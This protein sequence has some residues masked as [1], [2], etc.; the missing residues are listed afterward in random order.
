MPRQKNCAVP[1][2]VRPRRLKQFQARYEAPGS[3]PVQPFFQ[4]CQF[5]FNLGPVS[6][7][8]VRC[9]YRSCCLTNRAGLHLQAQI[10]DLSIRIE[11]ETHFD[12]AAAGL[13]SPR[14]ADGV[15]IAQRKVGQLN[16]KAKHLRRV[17][18]L[19]GTCL[20]DYSA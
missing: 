17:E 6:T 13:G 1:G 14:A 10:R 12:C 11:C 5:S 9:E 7:D 19:S 2:R 18:L 16:R 4:S 3:I 20:Q 15:T 8:C